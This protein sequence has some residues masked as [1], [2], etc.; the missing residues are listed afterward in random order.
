MK[1]KL[2]PYDPSWPEQFLGLKEELMHCIT[3]LNPVIEHVGST[4][5]PGLMA[6]PTIDIQI[7]MPGLKELDA[8]HDCLLP[9]GFTR[10][11]RWDEVVPF[12]RFFLKLGKLPQGRDI[13]KLIDS[14][15]DGDVRSQFVSKSNI[16]CTEISHQ[17]HSE[18]ILFRDYLRAHPEDRDAYQK[19]KLELAQKDWDITADYAKAKDIIIDKIKEK[20]HQWQR[21]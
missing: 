3:H 14:N 4:S 20:M 15:F 9:N 19:V 16:H 12:R 13:P 7:G 21:K 5:V 11:A 18:H 6:K 8:L 10:N 2:V 17:W 1:V